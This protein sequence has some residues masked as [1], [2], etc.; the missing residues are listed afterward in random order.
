MLSSG[1]AISVPDWEG[2]TG[3]V[4]S[5]RQPGYAALDGVRALTSGFLAANW[6]STRTSRCDR[7]W[8]SQPQSSSHSPVMFRNRCSPLVMQVPRRHIESRFVAIIHYRYMAT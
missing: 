5:P 8:R 7:G 4:F 6:S 1:H 2:P 3:S